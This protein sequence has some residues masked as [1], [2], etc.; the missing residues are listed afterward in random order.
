MIISI[1]RTFNVVIGKHYETGFAAECVRFSAKK[2]QAIF[3][4]L[5]V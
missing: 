1:S 2:I 5:F 4:P 3:Y